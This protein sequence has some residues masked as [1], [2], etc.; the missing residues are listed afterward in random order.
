MLVYEVSVC[1]T[2]SSYIGVS[3]GGNLGSKLVGPLLNLF[4]GE[5][6]IVGQS[7]PTDQSLEDAPGSVRAHVSEKDL[8]VDAAGAGECGV[9][10]VRNQCM[11]HIQFVQPEL[12]NALGLLDVMMSSRPS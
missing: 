10:E 2:C 11:S 7:R 8:L 6:G 1:L 4:H 12:T 9:L 3:Y 5:R